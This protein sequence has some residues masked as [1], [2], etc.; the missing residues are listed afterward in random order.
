MQQPAR[1]WENSHIV[2]FL[3]NAISLND[4]SH[5]RSVTLNSN[6]FSDK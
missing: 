2:S 1:R 3:S 5:C 6:F 4:F